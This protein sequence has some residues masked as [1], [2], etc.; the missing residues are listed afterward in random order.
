MTSVSIGVRASCVLAWAE[1]ASASSTVGGGGRLTAAG[2]DEGLRLKAW[3]AGGVNASPGAWRL[4][5]PRAWRLAQPHACRLRRLTRP[6]GSRPDGAE[7][8][9]MG[10]TGRPSPGIEVYVGTHR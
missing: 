7:C 3:E 6:R 8:S 9:R 5:Q 1:V 2:P 4:A 10:R